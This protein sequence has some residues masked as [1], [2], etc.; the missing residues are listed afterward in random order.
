MQI[1]RPIL[2][3]LVLVPTTMWGQKLT[4]LASRPDWSVLEKFQQTIT[5]DE[6]IRWLTGVYAP[7]GAAENFFTV[8][9][10]HVEVVTSPG[11]PPFRLGFAADAAAARPVPRYWQPQASL[12]GMTIALDPGHLGGEWARMEERWFQI[13]NSQPVAEGDMTLQVARLLK[14][15]LERRGA[16]VVLTRDSAKPA[17]SLRPAK[18]RGAAAAS[19]RDQ[20]R[21]LNAASVK[22][23]S[24][25][26]FYRTAE[27]RARAKAVNSSIKPDLVLA[28]HFNAESW[29]NPAQ[30]TLVGANHLHLLVSG[31]YGADE[32]AYEDQRFDLMVKLLNRSY[33]EEVAVSRHV[34]ASMARATGL[35]PYTYGSTS[36]INVGG[37]P[38]IWARNLLANRL[39]A[40]PVVYLEPYVMNNRD[41]HSRV[42]AGDYEGRRNVGGTPRESIYR[43]YV[44]GVVEGLVAHYGKN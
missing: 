7:R 30:P 29:G 28:L 21:P 25:R 17:T 23:E 31:C 5:R 35:P 24:E 8:R 12:E 34:A 3:L 1:F 37:S 38:Y 2:F 40:C 42:Q 43:E 10:D 22:S 9:D 6:F 19:L 13:G 33:G 27:I 44:R 11:R 32:L 26:L 14:K 39:F 15:E 16:R 4:P 18:L 36:A 41:V 20:G